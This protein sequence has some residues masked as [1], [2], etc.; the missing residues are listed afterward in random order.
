MALM[1]GGPMHGRA[2]LVGATPLSR[3]VVPAR[4]VGPG[5][6]ARPGLPRAMPFDYVEYVLRRVVLLE[7]TRA[8]AYMIY[9][10]PGGYLDENAVRLIADK[11][12]TGL[13][14]NPDN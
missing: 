3:L 14:P 12:V 5:V 10:G 7:F 2:L 8:T 6:L 9:F 13:P 11:R 4:E 1:L